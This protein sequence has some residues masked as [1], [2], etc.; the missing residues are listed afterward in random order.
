[1]Y[2]DGATSD[3]VEGALETAYSE[4]MFL[5]VPKVELAVAKTEADWVLLT[6]ADPAG[7]VKVAV[8]FHDGLGTEGAGGDG[9]YRESWERCDFSEFPERVAESYYGYQIWTGADG[10]PALTTEIVSYPGPAHCDWQATTFLSLGDGSRDQ[11][12]YAE[13][14]QPELVQYMEGEYVADLPLPDDAVA[15][16]YSRDGRRLWLSPDNRYAHVGQPS[17]VEAWPR[18]QVGCD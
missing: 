11:A 4:G 3:T 1:V 2:A 5:E 12:L 13:H 10:T 15:T 7:A 6:Y 16:P 9:W 18:A 14:P 8:V 17:S